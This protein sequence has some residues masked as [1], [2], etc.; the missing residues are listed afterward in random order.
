MKILVK[1]SGDLTNS[2]ELVDFVTEKSVDNFVVIICGGGTKI[3][4]ALKEAG[5]EIEYDNLGRRV[6]KT[7]GEK[8]IAANVLRYEAISLKNKILGQDNYCQGAHGLEVIP[9]YLSLYGITCPINGDDLLKAY[10]L[11]FDESYVF[12]K[13]DRIEK[14]SI[15]FKDFPKVRIVGI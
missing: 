7:E 13:K 15:I 12:T 14:K 3:S 1:A 4:A 10:Y 9:S 11:G 2:Q 8:S 5:Y 6:T